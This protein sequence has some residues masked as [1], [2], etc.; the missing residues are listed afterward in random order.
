MRSLLSPVSKPSSVL[1]I[2][3]ADEVGL[4]KTA[5]VISMIAFVM[6]T[7]FLQETTLKPPRILG[8]TKRTD[9]WGS[10]GLSVCRAFF[11]NDI[12]LHYWPWFILRSNRWTSTS[13]FPGRMK[14]TIGPGTCWLLKNPWSTHFYLTVIIDEAHCM[15]NAGSK[16]ISALKLL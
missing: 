12:P 1:E 8:E 3:I 11:F 14:T 5:Q 4:G 9:F 13:K 16:H 2:L 10:S 15:R 7:A 6:Q